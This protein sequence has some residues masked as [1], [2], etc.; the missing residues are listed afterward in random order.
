M[1]KKLKAGGTIRSTNN[2]RSDAGMF[3]LSLK[4]HMVEPSLLLLLQNF[5]CQ[6]VA[7][8]NLAVNFLEKQEVILFGSLIKTF[9]TQR[10]VHM[11]E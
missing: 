5:I 7:R 9:L 8:C 11:K 3:P 1:E 4:A 6:G 10:K 2:R